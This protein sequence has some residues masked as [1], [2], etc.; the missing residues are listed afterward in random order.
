[1]EVASERL[2]DGFRLRARDAAA[3]VQRH[4][5][6]I[7]FVCSPNNP[8]GNAQP[9]EAVRAVCEA[10]DGLV[11]VDEAYGEFVGSSA[12]ELLDRFEQLAVVRTFSKAF[13]LAGVR[14]GYCLADPALV[15]ELARVRLPY[16]LSALTQTAGEVAMRYV[17]AAS[18]ILDRIRAERDRLV[19]SLAEVE[20]VEVFPSDANFVLFRTGASAE[21]VWRALLHRGVLVRDVSAVQGLEGCL[22][23]TAGTPQEVDAFLEALPRAIEEAA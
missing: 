5:P 8:T 2:G 1:M 14:L 16:H 6:A 20:G 19:R 11:I 12:V 13:S 22:R 18:S 15:E 4:R 23:V 3:A 21:A 10:T 7:A 9:M 17:E